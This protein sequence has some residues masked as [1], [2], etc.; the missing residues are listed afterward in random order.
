[1]RLVLS[2][3]TVRLFHSLGRWVPW[4]SH[5]FGRRSKYRH[6]HVRAFSIWVAAFMRYP[7]EPS[8]YCEVSCHK[9]LTHFP[10]GTDVSGY[11]GAGSYRPEFESQRVPITA[12]G[13]EPDLV[14]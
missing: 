5:P 11:E 2:R 9:Y 13:Q 4:G 10:Y 6:V 8:G 7:G 14:R 1:M 3:P 12:L